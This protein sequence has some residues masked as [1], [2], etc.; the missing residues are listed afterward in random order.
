MTLTPKKEPFAYISSMSDKDIDRVIA[1]TASVSAPAGL[2]ER[3]II[4]L[5]RKMKAQARMRA[6]LY[7]LV[8]AVSGAGLFVAGGAALAGLRSGGTGELVSLV[9]SDFQAV[10]ANWNYFMLSLFESLPIL[11][12]VLALI[13]A[14]VLFAMVTLA[15]A[16]F[17]KA[18]SIKRAL[19][20][21]A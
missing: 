3:I 18:G 10:A 6:V 17:R 1:R 20:N 11:P 8:S 9:F 14:G 12:L 15:V 5:E 2:S 21:N 4:F 7:C 16:D 13:A 19:L